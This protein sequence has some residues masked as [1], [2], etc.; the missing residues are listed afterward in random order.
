[1]ATHP[2]HPV[3]LLVEDSDV[4]YVAFARSIDRTGQKHTLYRC[5]DGDEALDFLFEKGRY[6]DSGAA[7]RP[8]LILLDLNLPGTDGREVLARV[9]Q[10]ERLRSIPIVVL[11]SST[12]P[13]D[14]SECYEHGANAYQVKAVDYD[15]FKLDVQRAVDYWFG[16]AV[17]P[18][19]A[20]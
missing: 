18:A 1:M 17:V 7:P 11:T 15:R 13:R 12:N 2:P 4:D 6:A 3:I 8:S 16:T 14:V 19:P 10:D 9:K 20:A 5:R